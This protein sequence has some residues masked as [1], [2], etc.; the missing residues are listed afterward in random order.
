MMKIELGGGN[1]P[2]GN[3]FINVDKWAHE[4]VNVVCDF[5]KDPLPFESNS[6]DEIYSSHCFEHLDHLFNVIHE[7]VRVCKD[8]AKVVIRTPHPFAETA[9]CPSVHPFPGHKN[10]LSPWWWT[11][12]VNMLKL[13]LPG[14]IPGELVI[15]GFEFNRSHKAK[16]L[17]EGFIKLF[18]SPSEAEEFAD[19][20]FCGRFFDFAVIAIVRKK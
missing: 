2:A 13:E 9:M 15:K 7:I 4:S 10:V 5:E 8:G 6:V 12:A 1:K 14:S 3:G 11:D 16:P 20:H 19:T 17:P 18:G